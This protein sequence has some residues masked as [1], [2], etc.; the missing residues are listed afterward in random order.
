MDDNYADDLINQ[1]VPEK[2]YTTTS[3]GNEE[4]ERDA[5][6]IGLAQIISKDL[7]WTR[8]AAHNL[9]KARDY[10]VEQAKSFAEKIRKY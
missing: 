10:V 6:D 4:M 5:G 8:K 3:E 9:S 2:E 7:S 1:G